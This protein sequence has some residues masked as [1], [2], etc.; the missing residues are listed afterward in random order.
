MSMG[1]GMFDLSDK[2][3]LVTGAGSGLGRVYCEAFAEAGAK[4]SCVDLREEWAMQ[5]AQILASKGCET[6]ALRA[7]VTKQDEVKNMVN[8]TVKQ[9]GRLDIAVNNA[10]IMTKSSRMHEMPIEDWDRLMAVSLR[11]I[12]L[13]CYSVFG[14]MLELGLN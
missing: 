6:I 4:V 5:T 2:V 1:K 9:L 8:E 10:G 14:Y 12:F 7:D 13:A 11:G 3:T